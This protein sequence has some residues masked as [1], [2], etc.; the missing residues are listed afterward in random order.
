MTNLFAPDEEDLAEVSN[1]VLPAVD[2][3][4]EVVFG[5]ITDPVV[6][7]KRAAWSLWWAEL[8]QDY[9]Q[10]LDDE[11]RN[12]LLHD[13]ISGDVVMFKNLSFD[14]HVWLAASGLRWARLHQFAAEE[15]EQP[16]PKPKQHARRPRLI[17][18]VR[19]V[20]A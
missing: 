15:L 14:S 1:A 8:H 6:H 13:P 17:K 3:M 4:D 20:H 2:D 12:W 18:A 19:A 10:N 5:A 16:T 7:N 11:M 9:T